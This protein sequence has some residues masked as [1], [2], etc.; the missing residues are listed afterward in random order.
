[1]A[2]QRIAWGRWALN[3]GQVCLAPEYIIVNK[4]NQQKIIDELNNALTQFFGDNAQMSESYG[5]IIN[6]RHFKRLNN[7]LNENNKNIAIGGK[8]DESDNYISPTILANINNSSPVMNDEVFGPIISIFPVDNVRSD[9]IP[10]IQ[11]RPKPLAL[12][13]FSNDKLFADNIV[14]NTDAGGVSI[15]D[16]ISHFT[17]PSFPFG[18]T[19]HSGQ[20]RYH[21]WHSFAAF[22]H[23]KPVL[24]KYAGGEGA[25]SLRL[26]PY[27]D[28]KGKIYKL[29]TEETPK[30]WK[31]P[32]SVSPMTAAALAGSAY[33]LKSKL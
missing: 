17:F 28:F 22:C 3:A 19:G 30:K 25:Y 14:K 16:T 24:N 20:G 12:Y 33:F 4:Q 13:I 15:N 1:M 31:F 5:R 29:F 7:V 21:G 23:E 10:L 9:A 27:T 26:P 11:S 32:F 6:N 18:G 2:A 8:T